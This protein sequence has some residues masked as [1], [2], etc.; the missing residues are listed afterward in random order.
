MKLLKLLGMAF[1]FIH[2]YIVLGIAFLRNAGY[3]LWNAAKQTAEKVHIS[4]FA[5]THPLV[6]AP[7]RISHFM[8]NTSSRMTGS[9]WTSI[10]LLLMMELR[11]HC[12]GCVGREWRERWRG[13]GRSLCRC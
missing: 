10:A 9:L 7:V 4:P 2:Y 13:R 3:Y 6:F 11:S 8:Q 5:A 1:F 12:G